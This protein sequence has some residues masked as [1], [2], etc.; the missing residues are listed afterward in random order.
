MICKYEVSWERRGEEKFNLKTKE[1]LCQTR[2]ACLR[3]IHGHFYANHARFQ[4]KCKI[5]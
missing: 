2:P 5:Y 4:Y 3:I 1:D